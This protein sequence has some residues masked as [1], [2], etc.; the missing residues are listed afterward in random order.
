MD[1][2]VDLVDLALSS[3]YSFVSV[4]GP[5]ASGKTYFLDCLHK[6][7]ENSCSYIKRDFS[8]AGTVRDNL[9]DCLAD[10]SKKE[11]KSRIKRLLSNFQMMDF[12]DYAVSDL[13]RSQMIKLNI[14]KGIIS[15][16]DII[17]FDNVF[18][19]LNS[20]DKKI[21]FDYLMNLNNKGTRIIF[22]TTNLEECL[23]S[24]RVLGLCDCKKVFF[25]RPIK[26]LQD[27]KL[28]NKLGLEMPFMI[29]L[30]LKLKDYGLIKRINLDMDRMIDILWK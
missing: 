28:L 30:S 2:I 15:N 14:I 3:S 5:M 16:P 10:V 27:E 25:D 4:I 8:M 19:G 6:R 1:D 26:V 29:D 11:S 12:L 18:Y 22:T 20:I 9:L 17:L 13:T 23:I 24:G 21:V 7:C